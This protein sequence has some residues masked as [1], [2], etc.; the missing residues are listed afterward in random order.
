[1]R[2]LLFLLL[3]C[4][5]NTASSQC[6]S[7]DCA[8]GKG[9]TQYYLGIYEGEF[10]D[11]L[12][13]G[14]GKYVGYVG[15]KYR[16][17][18]VYQGEGAV[19][20]DSVSDEGL[21]QNGL[22]M[23]G[24]RSV[25]ASCDLQAA[26]AQTIQKNAGKLTVLNGKL[27]VPKA[28]TAK[29]FDFPKK[30]SYQ[31]GNNDNRKTVKFFSYSPNYQQYAFSWTGKL[32]GGLM[33]GEGIFSTIGNRKL[34][35]KFEKG[36]PVGIV[37]DIEGDWTGLG[38]SITLNDVTL[39]EGKISMIK[40]AVNNGA[41]L[42]K[43]CNESL[44]NI[45]DLMLF[46]GEHTISYKSGHIYNGTILNGTPHGYGKQTKDGFSY[47]GFYYKAYAHGFGKTTQDGV[48]Q[49]SGLYIFNK[50]MRGRSMRSGQFIDYPICEQGDC[51]NGFGK[52]NYNNTAD[53]NRMDMYEGNFINGLPF[54][55]GER[56][57]R[58][59]QNT[60]TKK[61]T[62][63]AGQLMGKGEITA[64][65]GLFKKLT[66]EFRSDTLIKGD[67]DYSDGTR[68]EAESEQSIVFAT[69]KIKNIV[70][71]GTYHTQKGS[72]IKGEFA[73]NQ[74][75]LEG[76][77]RS[78][79]GTFFHFGF[80]R[81][82]LPI[83]YGLYCHCGIYQPDLI[84][85]L[86]DAINAKA[87]QA[88][89]DLAYQKRQYAEAKEKRKL[90]AIAREK[91]EN[92][93]DANHMENCG[94]CN[95]EGKFSYTNTIGGRETVTYVNSNGAYISGGEKTAGRKYSRTVSCSACSGK[96]KVLIKSKK[97]VGPTF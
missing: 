62:F 15:F 1:M 64:N 83:K 77:Y 82:E 42:S 33:D 68:W 12:P 85:D 69:Q 37:S 72:I 6:L 67:I 39:T 55:F 66:G 86:A 19:S 18:M 51:Q 7:G 96:G 95:G 27:V 65:Y 74:C 93:K 10:R 57:Y 13:H 30:S 8:N 94:S 4:T 76:D 35:V 50:L 28:N 97:Y 71:T 84:D 47:E 79:A 49:D 53:A 52:V 58:D 32:S 40:F 73:D 54:G 16:G 38:K 89:A 46:Q 61:G 9:K 92:W 80:R 25:L 45:Q 20:V 90:Q 60:Y 56:T 59:K 87:A 3:S 17:D 88:M 2:Y 5:L 44:F 34:T 70:G 81:S 11:S 78:A 29:S 21:F 26:D 48:L 91:P 22:F 36:K 41:V 23:Y 24:K 75:F 43:V 14:K 31:I 63:S